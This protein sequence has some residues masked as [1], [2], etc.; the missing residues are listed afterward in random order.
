MTSNV[1]SIVGPDHIGRMGVMYMRSVLTQAGVAHEEFSPGEDYL[2]VDGNISFATGT[3]RVQIKTG[4][5]KP[6]K[7]GS[8]T[9]PL[10]DDWIRKWAL[11]TLPVFL[12]Y[13]RL[14]RDVGPEW[15]EH[16]DQHTVMYA[17]AQWIRVNQVTAKSVRVPRANRLTADTFND[18]AAEF[19]GTSAWGKAARL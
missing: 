9:V 7:D 17:R 16:H 2:A 10:R 5:T 1:Q 14:E 12:V 6:N 4:T 19:D 15:L 8:I 11:C 3:V 18:W 13:V